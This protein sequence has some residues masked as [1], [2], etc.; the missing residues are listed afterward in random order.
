[1][2][3][4]QTTPDLPTTAAALS[5]PISI[6]YVGPPDAESA[7]YGALVPGRV[8]QES[9]PAFATYLVETHPEHWARA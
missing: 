4:K 7:R 8:Y 5:A 9:D 6:T 2:A 1:M 3:K